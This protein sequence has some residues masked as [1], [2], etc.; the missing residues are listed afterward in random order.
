MTPEP[1]IGLVDCNNFYVSCEC[2]FD[3]ALRGRPVILLSN[4]NGCVVALSNEAKSLGIRRGDPLFRL[5]EVV[6]RAG[7]VVCS[8]NYPLYGDPHAGS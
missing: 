7:V 5:T 1:L 4:N 8:S 3:P 6:T 2:L